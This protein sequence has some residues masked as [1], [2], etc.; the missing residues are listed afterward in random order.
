MPVFAFSLTVTSPLPVDLGYIPLSPVIDF[1]AMIS[2]AGL[3]GVFDPNSIEVIDL[4]DGAV[5]P[6]ARTEDF[7]YGDAGRIEWVIMS[8]VHR[9]YEIRFRTVEKRPF[10]A[11]QTY[12]PLI[13]VGDLIRYNAG[14]PRPVTM[15]Y[16]MNLVDLTGDGLPD[17]VGCWNYYY[18]PDAPVSGLI[19]YPRVGDPEAFTFGDL[20]RLRYVETA[21]SEE[22]KHFEGVYVEADFADVNG[23]GLSDLVFAKAFSSEV[24]FFLNTGRRDSCGLPLFMKDRS[25]PITVGQCEGLCLV[26][27]NQDG[28]MDLVVNRQYVRNLNPAGWPFEPSEPMELPVGYSPAFLD[29]SG[30]GH[31]D[32]VYLTGTGCD[33]R[34]FWRRNEGGDTPL[35]GPEQPMEGIALASP[36]L[37]KAVTDGARRGLLV[38][39]DAYQKIAFMELA[40][41][42]PDGPV[43]RVGGIA[44]SV[45]APLSGSDQAWPCLCDWNNDGVT[46]LLIGGGYGWPRIVINDG[47]NER[48]AYREPAPILSE[49]KPIRILRD[50]LLFSRNW[51]NMG[52]PYPVFVDWDGDGLPD[53][54]LPNETNRIVWYRNIGSLP[55]PAF[56]PMQILEVDGYPDSPEARAH[57]GR[58]ADDKTLPNHPYPDDTTSPFWWRTGAAFGDWNGD[59]LMDLITHGT[60]RKAT[61]FVQYRDPSGHLRLRREGYVRL[62]DGR[63][64]DDAIVGREKHWTE[65]F[66][67]VDWDGDGLIDLVYNNAGTGRIFLLKNVGTRQAPVFAAAR[68]FRCYGESIGYTIHGPNAWAGDLNGDGKPDLIGAVE[69][70]V[71]PFLCHAALELPAHPAYEIGTACIR[72]CGAS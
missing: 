1:G 71:Y 16:G 60:D 39:H 20:T 69:W 67:A 13:G 33:Q 5:I 59:G 14:V 63:L 32:A 46:D 2:A 65:S 64:I 56:G 57:A 58:L 52:Y 36:T 44:S 49:G 40:D 17:L 41:H 47:T 24:T 62:E 10:L 72:D 27:L 43:W 37:L 29:L 42:T 34:V 38:Q 8:P 4:A 9:R 54:M 50:D 53:L 21:E 19:C 22:L 48:P 12:T 6:H 30:D 45:S 18:R 7:T 23:D 70:S 28:R 61:L 35:F 15:A 51:H 11:P 25:I 31:L 55:E 26:D 68:E 3:P 66:R